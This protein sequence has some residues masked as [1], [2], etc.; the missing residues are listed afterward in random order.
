MA[1]LLDTKF[2]GPFGWRF[3]WDGILG[4]IPGFGDAA[5]NIM[6]AYIIL[7]ATWMGYPAG[8]LIRMFM[9][10]VID[11]LLDAVPLLGNVVDFFFKANTR[12]IKLMHAYEFDPE[13]TRRRSW[14][15]VLGMTV[16]LIAV[17]LTIIV[18]AFVLTWKFF[19]WIFDGGAAAQWTTI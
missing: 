15:W 5:T 14:A 9:N 10:F 1:D 4:L 12:N 11:N 3:G 6:A 13:R 16:A 18:A 19:M 7:R 2:R 8:V 17:M